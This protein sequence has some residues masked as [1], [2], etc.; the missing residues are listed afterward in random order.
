MIRY[1]YAIACALAFTHGPTVYAQTIRQEAIEHD[2]DPYTLIA[3]AYHESRWIVDARRGKCGGLV[4][5]CGPVLGPIEN[6]Q[7]A[8]AL[9]EKNREYCERK[10]GRAKLRHW[11][12]SY[13]GLNRHGVWCGQRWTKTGWVDVPMHRI[14]ERVVSLRKKLVNQCKSK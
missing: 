11:L 10:T 14:T 4:G 12:P 13:Q 6:L 2:F 9:I 5:V 3:M 1:L 8:A 7:M